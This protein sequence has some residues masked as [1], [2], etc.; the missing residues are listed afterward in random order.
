MTSL[1]GEAIIRQDTEGNMVKYVTLYEQKCFKVFTA[2][3]T[4][5]NIA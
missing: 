1:Q 4:H 2:W 3:K 5:F